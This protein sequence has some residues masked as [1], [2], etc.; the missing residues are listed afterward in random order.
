MTVSTHLG[1]KFEGTL[2]GTNPRYQEI[3]VAD[4]AFREGDTVNLESGEVDLGATADTAFVGVVTATKSGLTASTS[5]IEV[6]R[7]ADAIYSAYDANARVM[8]V[9]LDLT[10]ATGAQTVTTKSNDEFVVVATST[11]LERTL[12]RF[13]NDVFHDL[14]AQT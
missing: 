14:V 6:C 3:V 1:F 2:S 7:N 10:G 9:A 8:G 4:T 12:V 5:V 11:A 13:N